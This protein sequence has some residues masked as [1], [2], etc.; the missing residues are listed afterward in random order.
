MST[1]RLNVN[2]KGFE[3][4]LSGAVPDRSEWTEPAMD[5]GILEFV[6]LITSLVVKYGGRIIHGAHPTFTPVI[7]RHAQQHALNRNSPPVTLV[8]S[9]L[10]SKEYS[11]AEL[12]LLARNAEV[13]IT[14]QIG[15]GG[16]D[17]IETR[18]RS[19]T[20]MRIALID[21]MN[22][23]IAVGGKLHTADG[24]LPGVAEELNL[25]RR[26][27]MPCFLVGGL[28]GMAAEYAR[29]LS[30]STV[31]QN[32]LSSDENE[33]LFQTDDVAST[34]NII[35]ERLASGNSLLNRHLTQLDTTAET[36]GHAIEEE[37]SDTEEN[38]PLEHN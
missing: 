31:L 11:R 38:P 27:G 9:E 28:G 32:G 19:L 21:R 16:P 36:T 14:P 17:N 33:K 37:I 20:R 30:S 3:V 25:A 22:V 12:N 2:L 29:G 5:R 4:G 6:A 13:V 10:F 23:M 35:F 1:T 7:L 24:R 8:M 34:V 26:R 18:N 15:D